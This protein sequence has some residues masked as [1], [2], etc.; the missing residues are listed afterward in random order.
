MILKIITSTKEASG[1]VF[2]NIEQ[3]RRATESDVRKQSM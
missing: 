2:E 3:Q 1:I